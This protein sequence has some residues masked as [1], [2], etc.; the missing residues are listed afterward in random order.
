MKIKMLQPFILKI[1]DY[2]GYFLFFIL[3]LYLSIGSANNQ[4]LGNHFLIF[5]KLSI[6]LITAGII[7]SWFRRLTGGIIEVMGFMIILGITLLQET[8]ELP[9]L[10][11]FVFLIHGMLNIVF[12]R[13]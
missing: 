6:I 4:G 7:F 10:Q 13:P 9:D 12:N 2:L 11:L 5:N 8:A 1:N 3:L